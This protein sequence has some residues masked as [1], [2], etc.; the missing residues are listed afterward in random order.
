MV[1]NKGEVELERK[2]IRV[3]VDEDRK[4]EYFFEINLYCKLFLFWMRKGIGL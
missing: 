4:Y 1:V 3:K 2:E